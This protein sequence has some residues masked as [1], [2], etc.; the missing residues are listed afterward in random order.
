MT[1]CI[2]A[3]PSKN[4]SSEAVRG[5][6]LESD[7]DA[8]TQAA[9]PNDQREGSCG[10]GSINAPKEV[11]FARMTRSRQRRQQVPVTQSF[12]KMPVHIQC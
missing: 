12:Q 7:G 10:S 5:S 4:R 3:G 8:S 11:Q 2:A 9:I 1:M 6:Q